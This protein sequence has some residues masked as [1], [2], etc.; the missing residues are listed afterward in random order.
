MRDDIQRPDGIKVR[1]HLLAADFRNAGIGPEGL[2]TMGRNT[3]TLSR[4]IKTQTTGDHQA[5]EPDRHPIVQPA[6]STTLGFAML[7]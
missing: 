6:T 1:A 7:G 3:E 4:G 5:A 2:E